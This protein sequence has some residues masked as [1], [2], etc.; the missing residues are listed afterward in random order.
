MVRVGVIQHAP[1][2]LD[3][4]ATLR[5]M[6]TLVS[7]A[8]V[9]GAQ[10]IVFPESFLPGYPSWIWRLAAEDDYVV[11]ASLH[12]RLLENSVSL[13][14]GALEAI[15]RSCQEAWGCDCHRLRRARR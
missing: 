8:V 6:E 1:V 7:Q 14:K 15:M 10:L 3:R 4:E 12:A 11:L 9:D 2:L 13:K 5:Q